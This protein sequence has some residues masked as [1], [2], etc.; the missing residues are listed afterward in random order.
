MFALFALLCSGAS[1]IL[2]VSPTRV[3]VLGG[4]IIRVRIS[5]PWHVMESSVHVQVGETRVQLL[6]ME[7][8]VERGQLAFA[9]PPLAAGVYALT[10]HASSDAA[11]GI[12]DVVMLG[13]P[14]CSIHY[15][16]GLV[17]VAS[18]RFATPGGYTVGVEGEN[19]LVTI[20][21][22]T[23]L[24][25]PPMQLRASVGGVRV[26]PDEH[27]AH[28]RREEMHP[29]II[30]AKSHHV[31][32]VA[33]SPARW[34]L[35][36]RLPQLVAGM[37]RLHINIDRAEPSED[38]AHGAVALAGVNR[39]SE[40][41]SSETGDEAASVLILPKV[42]AI[43]QTSAG[44]L[45]G[46]LIEIRGSG[47]SPRLEENLV[48]LGGH[49]CAPRRVDLHLLRC[50]LQPAGTSSMQ[51]SAA[52]AATPS[53]GPRPATSNA[54]TR[55]LFLRLSKLNETKAGCIEKHIASA[56]RSMR[57]R[58]LLEMCG[59]ELPEHSALHFDTS[60][61]ARQSGGAH[62]RGSESV[63]GK[64]PPVL[65]LITTQLDWPIAHPT[66]I[67]GAQTQGLHVGA[68]LVSGEATLRVPLD[69]VYS[70]AVEC[71]HA[72]AQQMEASYTLCA[73][74]ISSSELAGEEPRLLVRDHGRVQLVASAS[75][76]LR[77]AFI[78][79]EHAHA[80]RVRVAYDGAPLGTLPATWLSPP[81]PSKGDSTPGSCE[82]VFVLVRGLEA[83]HQAETS[84]YFERPSEAH[85]ATVSRCSID[86]VEV[87]ADPHR[88]PPLRIGSRI[89]CDGTSLDLS[90]RHADPR[91][92]Q[93]RAHQGLAN[94]GEIRIG[95][96]R[97]CSGVHAYDQAKRLTCTVQHLP[98]LSSRGTGELRVWT[99]GGGWARMPTFALQV[100]VTL[101][102]LQLSA[103]PAPSPFSPGRA[104]STLSSTPFFSASSGCA[105]GSDCIVPAGEHWLLDTDLSVRTLTVFG[106]L[107]WDTRLDNLRLSAGFV[108]VGGAG[109]FRIGS[110]EAPM[111]LRATI[112]IESNGAT[113]PALGERFFGAHATESGL[114]PLIEIH[115]RP[116]GRTWSL[117]AADAA[118]GANVLQLQ[119]APKTMGWQVGDR[120]GI[121]S[122]LF[123]VG[124]RS[125]THVLV[126]IG[127]DMHIGI[128][129]PLEFHTAGG[130][131]LVAGQ[132]VEMSA[133]I[134]NLAR[135][136]T[137]SGSLDGFDDTHVGLHTIVSKARAVIE[138][139]RIEK[140]GQRGRAGRYCMH[141]HLCRQCPTCKFVGNAIED[142][143]HGG[144]T[145][146][147]TH[148]A[149]IENNVLW[150]AARPSQKPTHPNSWL[151]AR[152]LNE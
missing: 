105:A 104:L 113:H 146:H 110:S 6:H 101:P 76:A 85:T 131:R 119:H 59:L 30:S 2:D 31:E 127:D 40:N 109:V 33:L 50:E 75:Y 19:L 42:V 45:G 114:V 26:R 92:L 70:F 65:E 80:V 46:A 89:E 98:E 36:L 39:R 60:G 152:A 67:S 34:H 82:G 137:I 5:S 90:A 22:A 136:V 120:I 74:E 100:N 7:S 83:V 58:G 133:E 32:P 37:H 97:L 27:M 47:F 132:A 78:H 57:L 14:R 126:S 122:T 143:H 116:L 56:S 10:V 72:T 140:C 35:R 20:D 144:I 66:A 93:A 128:D 149:T 53:D 121:A 112:F 123:N 117:L 107:S 28:C 99:S 81:T 86:G 71:P 91:A 139:A 44:T 94:G 8:D 12:P 84:C 95:N 142:S 11:L 51:G 62:V 49:S 87:S 63:D 69:G 23:L 108:L 115:G 55:G 88:A 61:G 73:L 64:S 79:L 3:G 21:N 18:L 17:P 148:S 4:A 135:S 68:L 151:C 130:Q 77:L 9:A 124:Q 52:A 102:M 48:R 103:V 15:D 125:T 54:T 129:P 25:N 134:V 1:T 150:Y 141:L 38:S 43:S 106:E 29:H 41:S 138:H 96:V 16:A 147:G 13:C 24:H 111:L 145:V 118:P